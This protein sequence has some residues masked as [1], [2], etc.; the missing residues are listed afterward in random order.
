[1][2]R[3]QNEFWK[4]R[5]YDSYRPAT[6]RKGFSEDCLPNIVTESE[7]ARTEPRADALSTLRLSCGQPVDYSL[8][9]AFV[10][11]SNSPSPSHDLDQLTQM[12]SKERKDKSTPDTRPSR[13]ASRTTGL[14]KTDESEAQR[15]G[16]YG[17]SRPPVSNGIILSGYD[18]KRLQDEEAT[19]RSIKRRRGAKEDGEVGT[20]D[21][22]EDEDEPVGASDK[23]P[24]TPTEPASHRAQRDYL[25][26]AHGENSLL[27]KHVK[28]TLPSR[29][30]SERWQSSRNVFDPIKEWEHSHSLKVAPTEKG[31]SETTAEQGLQRL[32]GTFVPP[33][34]RTSATNT[35]EQLRVLTGVAGTS[36]TSPLKQP[37][38]SPRDPRLLPPALT[39]RVPQMPGQPPPSPS[40]LRPPRV[41]VAPSHGFNMQ[42]GYQSHYP[43]Q[44]EAYIPPASRGKEDGF[45]QASTRKD[46]PH[47]STLTQNEGHRARTPSQAN[48]RSPQP[49]IRNGNPLIPAHAPHGPSADESHDAMEARMARAFEAEERVKQEQHEAE[50]AGRARLQ[51]RELEYELEEKFKQRG[52]DAD[53][54]RKA[55]VQ[56]QEEEHER[57]LAELRRR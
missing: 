57:L 18:L 9:A 17:S 27:R 5:R 8:S 45:S 42:Q 31:V 12:P 55:A 11:D 23:A 53:M 1:M 48:D 21:E 35:S 24:H 32:G 28:V 47:S 10:P 43:G 38:I 22:D 26:N 16:M 46:H 51:R 30:G 34:G 15:R 7:T 44:R 29:D 13:R 56:K 2:P 14:D 4:Y 49:P 52:H 25:L 33:M 19:D 20:G 39:S 37:S 6:E 36:S 3:G 54:V 50:L 41:G 40:Y